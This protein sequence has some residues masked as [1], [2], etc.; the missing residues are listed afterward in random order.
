MMLLL[1][2]DVLQHGLELTRTHGER[3]IPALPGKAAMASAN[4][5]DPLRRRL[6]DLLD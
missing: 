1:R 6:L 2:L 5:F 3:G 4:C